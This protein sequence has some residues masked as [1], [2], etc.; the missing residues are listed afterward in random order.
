M[1]R[2]ETLTFP[3]IIEALQQ[4]WPELLAGV[5]VSPSTPI[6][7]IVRQIGKRLGMPD[8][9][10]ITPASL[11]NAIFHASGSEVKLKDIEE[12]ED[13]EIINENASDTP[14]GVDSGT[15]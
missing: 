4:E 11:M 6:Y 2:P 13:T 3:S 9:E 14:L 10:V 5:T 7:K 1:E 8:S 15:W 12:I